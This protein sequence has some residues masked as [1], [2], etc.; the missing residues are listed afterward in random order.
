MNKSIFLSSILLLL[1]GLSAC[2]GTK[3][4]KEPEALVIPQAIATASDQNLTAT[5]DW[6]IYRDGPGTWARNVD[7]D[8][9]LI[10]VY[11]SCYTSMQLTNITVIDSLGDSAE[12]GVS[13]KKLVQASKKTKKRYKGQG[14]EVKAGMGA[15]TLLAVGAVTAA[16][17][18]SAGAAVVFGGSSALAA[19]AVTGVLLAPALA[20]G[21][22]VRG[23]NNSKVNN[24]IESRQ[25]L[26]PI[27]LQ[28]DEEQNLDIF[29]PLSP[30]P[31]QVQLTYVDSGGEQTL[32]IDT[33][34]VLAGLHLAKTAE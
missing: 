16:T 17:A 22:I 34:A 8:E 32:I 13:R 20:V 10:R 14:L 31:R 5:L 12:V 26:L 7:W 15:G 6:V 19:G 28:K 4:L 2:G 11:N 24:Q 9:Y 23:V 1:L 30:S 3:M 33:Q 21:G 18:A 27:M 29:F 25:T